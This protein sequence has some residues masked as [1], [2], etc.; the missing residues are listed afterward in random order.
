LHVLNVGGGGNRE[1]PAIYKGWKQDLLDIDANVKPDIVCDAK[2]MRRLPASKYDAIFCSHNLEHFYKHEVPTVLG[3]FVHVLKPNGFAHVSVP[4]MD[5]LFECIVKGNR[6]IDDTWYQCGG[7]A[8][9]FHDVI[10]GWGRQVSQGNVYYSH[11]CGF[12]EKSLGKVLR[13]A[14]FKTVLT[15][16]DSGNL[17]AFAFK[18]KPPKEQLKRLGL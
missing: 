1:I 4:D 2:D 15:A 8:I 7:G 17:H 10:Y 16:A 12:T 11:K 18:A 9:S 14:G 5:S 3:G 13:G 6:D